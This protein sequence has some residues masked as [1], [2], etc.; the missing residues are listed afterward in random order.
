MAKNTSKRM[1]LPRQPALRFHI[2]HLDLLGARLRHACHLQKDLQGS[3]QT[4]RGHPAVLGPESATFD[5]RHGQRQVPV[6]GVAGKRLPHRQ[7]QQEEKETRQQ[8]VQNKKAPQG[9]RQRVEPGRRYIALRHCRCQAPLT[10]RRL[11]SSRCQF[12]Q[13]FM[14]ASFIQKCFAQFFSNYSLAL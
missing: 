11:R 7:R 6:S 13:R 5:R 3:P 14:L 9:G 4:E 10:H 12:H 8:E 2:L 1:Y